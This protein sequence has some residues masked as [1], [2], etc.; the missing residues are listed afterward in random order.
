MVY[1]RRGNILFL[2]LGCGHGPLGII[3]AKTNSQAKV[4]MVDSNL[5]AVRY[6]KVNLIKNNVKNGEVLGSLGT[7][8]VTD[9]NFDL[10]VSALNRLIPRVC[11]I[12][13]I[14]VKE[15]RKRHGYTVYRIIHP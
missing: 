10:V 2:D 6:A 14:K 12:N 1:G 9:R 7:E 4:T 13:K 3:L 5:L 15:V 8:S 11:G